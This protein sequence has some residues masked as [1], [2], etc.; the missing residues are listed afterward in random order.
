[1]KQIKNI[2]DISINKPDIGSFDGT[3]RVEL[4]EGFEN[5]QNQPF[6]FLVYNI[7]NKVI[8]QTKL[9]SNIFSFFPSTAWAHVKIIDS[10]GNTISSW[11]YD[12]IR[13]GCACH[14]LFY[15]WCLKNRGSFGIAIGTNDA[16]TGEY[17]GPIN[18]GLIKGLLIEA[19]EKQFK[20]LTENYKNKSWV[21]CENKLITPDGKPTYF[22]EAG[23]GHVNS[24][25]KEHTL[26]YYENGVEEIF[27]ESESLV[28]LLE[29]N[30]GYRWL[31]MDVEGIDDDLI[32][33]LEGRN[34][35]LP[36]VLI[37]EH[38]SLN[39]EQKIKV[40]EFLEKNGYNVY[41]ALSRNSI[42]FK[43]E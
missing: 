32:L 12:P 25:I 24:V 33:S 15:M 42:A 4:S 23:D 30:I 20:I 41:E 34:E 13:D 31:H 28:S 7:F 10:L 21:Y 43:N 3:I 18:E 39:T 35:L 16:T 22:Y 29:K 8:W 38:D 6:Y 17:V 36:E 11:R 37:Y 40:V 9:T 26:Q 2:I 14:Q 27:K 1:M 19:S 5:I